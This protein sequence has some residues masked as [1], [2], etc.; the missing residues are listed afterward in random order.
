MKKIIYIFILIFIIIIYWCGNQSSLIKV[1]EWVSI[2]SGESLMTWQT[3]QFKVK[4]KVKHT[5]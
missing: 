3:D 4:V 1:D 5:E 2:W